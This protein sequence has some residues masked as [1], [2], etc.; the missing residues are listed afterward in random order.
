[1]KRLL[2]TV[3]EAGFSGL[4]GLVLVWFCFGFLFWF[5]I[6]WFCLAGLLGLLVLAIAG[7]KGIRN[8]VLLLWGRWG[9]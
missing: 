4:G 6:L 3:Q 1:M 7:R 9:F 5:E 8:G 2:T